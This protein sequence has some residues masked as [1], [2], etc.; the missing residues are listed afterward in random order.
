MKKILGISIIIILIII[1]SISIIININKK[2]EKKIQTNE[3]GWGQLSGIKDATKEEQVEN[4]YVEIA[5]LDNQTKNKIQNLNEFII[6]L[7][8]Y[9]FSNGK[10][11]GNILEVTEQ[12]EENNKLKIKFKFNDPKQTKIIA[13]INLNQEQS[14]EFYYYE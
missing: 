14:Y 4:F 12:K 9:M 1:L 5:N 2:Q 7:K 6:E 3:E 13:T 10:V 8:Y 11:E